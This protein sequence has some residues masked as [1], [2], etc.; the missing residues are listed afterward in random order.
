[1]G[2][3]GLIAVKSKQVKDRLLRIRENDKYFEVVVSGK[4]S[5][6]VDR[7][8]KPEN[9]EIVLHNKN[10]ETDSELLFTAIHEYTH[11][12]Q[13]TAS[14]TSIS[15]RAHINHFWS[16]FKNYNATRPTP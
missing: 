9:R 12:L 2:D 15:G 8:Y 14:A 10:F 1:M 16:L 6:K 11:H 7:L 3:G 13:F 5:S 4:W